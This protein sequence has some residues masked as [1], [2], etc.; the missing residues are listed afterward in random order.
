M[1][2]KKND[3]NICDSLKYHLSLSLSF[4]FPFSIGKTERIA[5][6]KNNKLQ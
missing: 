1:K 5:Q 6:I 2:E 3:G 4:F